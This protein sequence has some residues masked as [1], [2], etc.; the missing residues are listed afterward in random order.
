MNKVKGGKAPGLDQCAVDFLKEGRRNMVVLL[1]RLFNFC[2]ETG[3]VPRDWCRACIA[4]L[5]KGKGDKS[6]EGHKSVECSG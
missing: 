6:V 5:Y 4:L 3:R 2:F 1:L